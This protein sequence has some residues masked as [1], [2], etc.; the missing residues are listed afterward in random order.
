MP[1]LE[2]GAR[3]RRPWRPRS[4]AKAPCSRLFPSATSGGPGRPKRSRQRFGRH[5]RPRDRE[6]QVGGRACPLPRLRQQEA[7]GAPSTSTQR[8]HR[9]PPLQRLGG[10]GGPSL[11]QGGQQGQPRS[12][13]AKQAAEPCFLG[14]VGLLLQHNSLE[15]LVVRTSAL[16]RTER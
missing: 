5:T 1:F 4:K 14:L 3:G 12:R 13:L 15:S 9:Q 6:L 10:V 7:Q 2:A 11:Q 8:L 16:V